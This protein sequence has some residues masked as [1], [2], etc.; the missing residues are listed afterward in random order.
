MAITGIGGTSALTL[1]TIGDMR[2]QLD[3]LQRQL[4]SGMKSTSY[5]GLG[6]DR[7]LSVGLRSQ[8]SSIDGYQQSIT[9][10]GVRL[11]L[12]QTALGQFSQI[13]QSTKSTIVQSQFALNGKTQTQDQ[14]NSKAV[15]D[16]M[17]GLLNTGADGRYLFSGRS[18]AQVPVETSDHILNG[19]GLKAGLKQI[20]DERRQADL[21][22]GTGR[23]TVGGSGTQ[24]SLTED[25]GIYGMKLVGATTNASG[26]TVTGPSPS[27][28]TLTV[29]LG[30][31]N[32]NPGDVVSFTFKMPDGTTRDLK[33]TATTASPPGDGQ[34]TIGA[35]STDTAT[36][37]Q[38]A[39]SQGVSTMAQTEL[40]AASAVQA[41]N[42]FFNTDANH[43]PQRVDGPPFDTAT[44]AKDGTSADTVSWYMGDNAT[45]DPRST[46]QARVDTSQTVSYGARANEEALRNSIQNVALF[47]A[48]SFSPSDPN[49]QGQYQALTQRLNAS[50][51]GSAN[52][53]S[54]T[55]LSGEL[56]GAQTAINNAKDRHS[57]SST[58]L[59][60]LL[61]SI[62]GAPQE[63]VAS[64]ILALQTSLQAT[65]QTTALLLKTS[66][67]NYL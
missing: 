43:P 44:Q 23:V 46:A 9:Q 27:P 62:E 51:V 16:Q 55:D 59:T 17:L 5:A 50:L 14:I 57:Q 61:Q 37:L 47:V 40:V 35:T 12:M 22:S 60:N 24:V 64:Q 13:T 21:G 2:N 63:L 7:G 38:G 28:A 20:I 6:L 4:G 32:P 31:T 66:L 48:T 19:D 52:Q 45:D 11:D 56:A 3:D 8:L 25:A 15:L 58:T 34:F 42:D 54:V 36:N 39:L 18:V 49:S 29:D 67:V 65:L 30:G 10:V 33:L 41:G 53:Q 26:A 1:L